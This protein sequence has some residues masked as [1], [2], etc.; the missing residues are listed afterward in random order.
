M[1]SW[2]AQRGLSADEVR[3][4]EV[5]ANHPI[6][7]SNTYLFSRK[8]CGQGVLVEANP[9]L[10]DA[11]AQVRSRDH[12]LNKAVV[13]P[14]YPARVGINIS[15]H[16]ELSSLDPGH[17]RSFGK[18]GTIDNIV[19]VESIGLDE[20]LDTYFPGGLHL[21]SVDI[22][23][24]DLEVLRHAQLKRRPVFIITEPSRH[25]HADAEA[26]FRA[27]LT[28]KGY[29]ELART[30]YNLIFGDSGALSFAATAPALRPATIRTFDVFDTLIAR[31]CIAAKAVFAEVEQRSGL[32]GFAA[33]REQSERA[34]EQGEYTLPD[35][36]AEFARRGG[37]S[38]EIAQQLQ[39]M[40][41]QVELEN[42]VPIADHIAE[43]DA[44][45]VLV[46]DMY[47]PDEVIRLLLSAAGV[48]PALPLLR[49]AHGKRSGRVW[50]E[51]ARAGMRCIHLG[52]NA[53]S[54]R[55]QPIAAGM[56][57]RLTKI[58]QPTPT[59]SK[60]AQAGCPHLAQS[61]RAARLMTRCGALP[62]HLH[63]L[64]AELNLPLLTVA[65]LTLHSQLNGRTDQRVLFASRDARYLHSIFDAVA[66]ASGSAGP[67]TFYW[68][69]SRIARTRGDSTYLAYCRELIGDNA[70]VV[71]LCGTGASLERLRMLLRLPAECMEVF[72]CQ[73]IDAPVLRDTLVA[74]YGLAQLNEPASLWST[75]DLVGNEVLEL[76]NYVPEGM[77]LGVAAVPGGFVPLREE[78]EFEGPQLDQVQEQARM[79]TEFAAN[80]RGALVP[81]AFEEVRAATPALVAAFGAIVPGLR[82]EIDLL[83]T[84]WLGMHR[85]RE[86]GVSARLGSA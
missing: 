44:S 41:L 28:A 18:I 4:L 58:A 80:L 75:R 65:A 76:L 61:L 32:Q 56:S 23:G 45:S 27:V 38:D 60:I 69:T 15:T 85:D 14:G 16:A 54:D 24:L 20:L 57:A 47:L 5:G 29:V 59:E 33:L 37:I 39:A 86:T 40:E 8:W 7:T 34:V 36:Y 84:S 30:E 9:A 10:V 83:K 74:R 48:S 35:I 2:F 43:L 6:Q 72:L 66:A 22:E 25:Y 12:V 67:Q 71:D 1:K 42:V 63:R 21:L 79:A 70:L 50:Q 68:H 51:F 19:E 46:S 31:R 82:A 81:A 26:G 55:A 53:Q 13:P 77:T 11:L 64:H 49:S 73:R 62:A 78:L 3:Y 52:D 17:V